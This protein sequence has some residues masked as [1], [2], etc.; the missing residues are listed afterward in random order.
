MLPVAGLLGAF[1]VAAVP[2]GRHAYVNDMGWEKLPSDNATLLD[3]ETSQHLWNYYLGQSNPGGV[4]ALL[5]PL[6]LAAVGLI[7]SVVFRF[8]PGFLLAGAWSRRS[9]SRSRSCPRPGSGTPAC[10]P[11]TSCASSCWPAS[12][13]PR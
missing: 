9:A 8:R 4:R 2:A 12:A 3:G 11:S 1:W 13:W 7:V 10:C 5:W 6:A